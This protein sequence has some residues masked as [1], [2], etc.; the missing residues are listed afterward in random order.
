MADHTDDIQ[1]QRNIL[2]NLFDKLKDLKNPPFSDLKK[3]VVDKKLPSSKKIL[4]S[5]LE[6]AKKYWEE[7]H[8]S[9]R[10][11]AG[12]SSNEN[13]YNFDFRNKWPNC[14]FETYESFFGLNTVE[15]LLSLFEK[16]ESTTGSS[17]IPIKGISKI[18]QTKLRGMKIYDVPT[19]LMRGKTQKQRDSIAAKLD[20][21]V[22]YVN[23]W[24]KQADLW[25]IVDMTPDVAYLL[26]QIGVRHTE[27]L[28]KVDENKAY[29]IMERLCLAQPDFSLVG[30]EAL[31][32]LIES[33]GLLTSGS[34]DFIKFKDLLSKKTPEEL[35]D[36]NLQAIL[37]ESKSPVSISIETD[38]KEPAYLFTDKYLDRSNDK[39]SGNIIRDGLDFLKDVILALPLPRTISGNVSMKKMGQ[40][41]DEKYPFHDSLVEISGIASPS[42]DKTES[43]NNPSGYTDSNGKFIIVMPDKYNF[44]DFIT[45]T[46]S[47]GANKQKFIKSASEIINAVK[48]QETLNLFD[49]L[50]DLD[51]ILVEKREVL[52]KNENDLAELKKDDNKSE[53]AAK[54]IKKKSEDIEEIEKEIEARAKEYEE[55][56]ELIKDSDPTTN[57]LDQVL[58]NLLS[59]TDLQADLSDIILTEDIFKGYRLDQKKT[60][61]SVKLMGNDETAIHLST[62][63]APSRVFNYSMLQRLV[64]PNIHPMAGECNG[65]KTLI[66]PINVMDFKKRL[67]EN[68]DQYP[69]MSSL[70]I[71]YILKMHQAWVPDG[72]ALGTLLY[73][74]VL[75]PGEEQRLVVREKSQSYI[76]TDDAEGM[77]SVN[78]NTMLSQ[79][80]DTTATYQYAVNQLS[81][82]NSDYSYSAKT[83]SFGAGLGIGGIFKGVSAMLGLSGGYSK[84][85]G[86]ASSSASQSNS[87]NEASSAA[88]SFQHSIKSSSDKLSQ[89][90]RISMRTATS[91]E[92]DSVATKIIANHNHSHAMT[93]QYWEVMRRYRLETCVEGVELVLFVPL[94]LIRFLPPGQLYLPNLSKFDRNMFDKRYGTLLQYADV[95]EYALPYKYRSGLNLIKKYAAYPNWSIEDVESKEK[96][97]EFTFNCNLYTFDD[98]TATLYLANG[99]GIIAGQVEY[100]RNEVD[101]INITDE[102]DD[103]IKIET[104]DQLKQIIKNYRNKK[105]TVNVKCTF[106]IPPD[107]VNDE[108]LYVKIY[109]SCEGLN[110]TL[111]KDPNAL[112]AS[113]QSAAD[114]YNYMMGKWW[115]SV[116]DTKDTKGDLR[117][118]DYVK[119]ILP[120]AYL[121][122]NVSLS[123][124][125]ILALGAPTI[126][127]LNMK[128]KE[129]HLTASSNSI[130]SSITLNIKSK[131]VLKYSERMEMEALMH[132]VASDTLNYSQIVWGSL[133]EDERAMMLEQYTIDMDFGDMNN[134]NND[135]GEIP[136]KGSKEDPEKVAEEGKGEG[137][138]KKH[139]INIPLLNCV[140]VKSVL[141]FYG[142]CIL[143]PFTYPKSLAEQLGKTA[144]EVQDS[145]YRYHTSC[146]RVPTTTISLPTDGMIGEAVLGETNV[147]EVIDLTRFWNWKD[148]PIDKMEIGS[149]YLN[150]S[151]Y[152]AN[153]TTKDITALNLQGAAPATPVT[154]ADLVSALVNKPVPQFNDLTALDQLRDILNEGTKSAAA[155]RDKAVE[156]SADLAKTAL[157]AALTFETESKKAEAENQKAENDAKTEKTKALSDTVNQLMKSGALEK[158]NNGNYKNPELAKL[159]ET[160]ASQLFSSS[161]S[162][163][164]SS[165]PGTNNSTS[166][167]SSNDDAGDNDDDPSHDGSGGT[168]PPGLATSF[169]DEDNSCNEQE[170]FKWDNVRFYPQPYSMGCWAA[171]SSMLLSWKD[172]SKDKSI[173]YFVSKAKSDEYL[174]KFTDEKG[175]TPSEWKTYVDLLKL[176]RTSSYAN[177]LPSEYLRLLKAHGPLILIDDE[178]PSD[179]FAIHARVLYGMGTIEDN[180]VMLFLDPAKDESNCMVQ[181]NFTTFVKK[182]QEAA[183]RNGEL[184]DQIVHLKEETGEM[185]LVEDVAS[186]EDVY[187]ESEI[188][189][190]LLGASSQ[191]PIDSGDVDSETNIGKLV[192]IFCENKDRT[193]DYMHYIQPREGDTGDP[194]LTI[195]FAHFANSNAMEI[196]KFL[197]NSKDKDISSIVTKARGLK[198]ACASAVCKVDDN[199]VSSA[200]LMFTI[201][202]ATETY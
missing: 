96:T 62:D 14:P 8:E 104:T 85:S 165:S 144:A 38:E 99:K 68:P 110:Y 136:E 71:G 146:F 170:I 40:K 113:G 48:E 135:E 112:A 185:N 167:N 50:E 183:L 184:Y 81:K 177:I 19:L 36:L 142:N 46:I 79:M 140:N 24:V 100:T 174:K 192:D 70:G 66:D 53:E 137:T 178:N 69:Q 114:E 55:I 3:M 158:D 153:K 97:I 73:S 28:S 175:L 44:E 88:Q 22:K 152:L 121:A 169:E 139:K 9:N 1:N 95:L 64:E 127:D 103:K 74:L 33:A 126:S 65:R 93:I 12:I 23:S 125:E 78:E 80:D 30:E 122:P 161:D 106:T 83:S 156:T 162:G 118:I 4:K 111:Y 150:N 197:R 45:I 172:N 159:V 166:N 171:S 133:S 67:Y 105:G 163:T 147:S 120:E 76:V 176:D 63:T 59:R 42:S 115:D 91:E 182:Y 108:L 194:H 195:G 7:Y 116:K 2:F 86:K 189:G 10:K 117:K 201:L 119:Q 129:L 191:T 15:K 43:E 41:D 101:K 98:L 199:V 34:I 32:L 160:G 179:A 16:K 51:R 193:Y 107:I 89:S 181:E 187:S 17:L 94:K 39:I 47:Q 60:L 154:A 155:G 52:K 164:S 31:T 21:D 102:D 198:I 90:K 6:A 13:H 131:P 92:S 200:D 49:K 25:R 26:V 141:G 128:D 168:S 82:A 29:P 202:D 37:N 54:E 180:P 190:E 188:E 58:Y 18:M 87:H 84:S 77:D 35:Q 186:N 56:R 11:N 20:V 196:I 138:D 57:Y 75:A 5:E 148:S 173:E 149:D 130:Y 143:L 72:F 27:D 109:Y 157:G 124:K 61:P 151:D 132:H 134:N 145:L 123:P